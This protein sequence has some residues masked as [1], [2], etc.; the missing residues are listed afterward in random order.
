MNLNYN[1]NLIAKLEAEGKKAVSRVNPDSVKLLWFFPIYMAAFIFVERISTGVTY[2]NTA[3]ALD[4]LIPFNEYF[5]IPYFI[6]HVLIATV[7]LLTLFRDDWTYRKLMKFMIWGSIFCFAIFIIYPNCTDLRP[8]SFEHDNIFV[9]I[10]KLLY[11]TDTPTNVCP[12]MH[13]VCSY[14]LLFAVLEGRDFKF[15][16]KILMIIIVT[17]IIMSTL[18]LKQHAVVDVLV[19]APVTFLTWRLSFYEPPISS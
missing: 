14:G 11:M 5:V 6:W 10:V 4:S 17:F 19:A 9:D 18:F 12:S 7:I 1:S 8:Q 13:V 16:H 15:F 2:H 3:T